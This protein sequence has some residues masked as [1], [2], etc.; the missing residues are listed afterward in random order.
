MATDT[1]HPVDHDVIL[2]WVTAPS[3][4]ADALAEALVERR[5]A[6]CVTRIEG[7]QSVYHWQG[8]V[9]RARE[10]LLMIKTTHSRFAALQGAILELHPYELPEI[11]SVP[12]GL[13]LPPYLTWIST[14]VSAP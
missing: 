13:G 14:S 12:V 2:V 10:D 6:A 3:D 11:L 1:P 5:L 9:E 4:A 7:T 8:A